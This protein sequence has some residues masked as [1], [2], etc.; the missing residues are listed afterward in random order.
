MLQ[1]LVFLLTKLGNLSFEVFDVLSSP[2]SDNPLC[3]SVIC[4]LPLKL[5]V[6]ERTD[7]SR[8]LFTVGGS[9]RCG[10]IIR[11]PQQTEVLT[12]LCAVRKRKATKG[13][14]LIPQGVG[15]VRSI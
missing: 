13:N 2:L 11:G 7:A 12:V 15:L 5:S 9:L 4:T 10:H 3:F 14:R 1:S 8:A 6:R